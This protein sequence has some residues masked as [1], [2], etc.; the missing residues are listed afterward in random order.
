MDC[1]RHPFEW[2]VA[3]KA[4]VELMKRREFA[5]FLGSLALRKARLILW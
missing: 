3:M 1:I 2:G 5:F 4:S